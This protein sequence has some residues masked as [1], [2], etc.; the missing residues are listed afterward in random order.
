M[1]ILVPVLVCRK[2][3]NVRPS[4]SEIIFCGI[5]GLTLEKSQQGEIITCPR[6]EKSENKESHIFH[7]LDTYCNTCGSRLVKQKIDPLK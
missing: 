1:N 7:Q 3:K 2:C 6:G 4:D 5:C